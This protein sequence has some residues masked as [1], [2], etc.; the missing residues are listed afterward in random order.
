MRK[1]FFINIFLSATAFLVILLLQTNY[2]EPAYSADNKSSEQ[3]NLNILLNVSYPFNFGGTPI[4][5]DVYMADHPQVVGINAL[6]HSHEDYGLKYARVG[7]FFFPGE[8]LGSLTAYPNIQDEYQPWKTFDVTEW[9]MKHPSDKYYIALMT[10]NI[11]LCPCIG[12]YL[13]VIFPDHNKAIYDKIMIFK[14]VNV[15]PESGNASEIAI[16]LPKLNQ[17]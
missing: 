15:C 17:H 5:A 10:T 6:K 14:P 7:E 12:A 2:S 4:S 1:N 13:E 11:N 9:I 16:D 3:N 8:R